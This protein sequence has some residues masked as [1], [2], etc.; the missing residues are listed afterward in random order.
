MMSTSPGRVAA[1]L[2]AEPAAVPLSLEDLPELRAADVLQANEDLARWSRRVFRLS[3][4]HLELRRGQVPH[5]WGLWLH[6][7]AAGVP[8]TLGL[9]KPLAELLL[10]PDQLQLNGMTQPL[11]ELWGA[12]RLAGRMPEGVE[13]RAVALDRDGLSQDCTGAPLK[14][15]WKAVTA[16][17]GQPTA[18]CAGMWC[19]EHPMDDQILAWLR[20]W[21]VGQRPPSLAQCA[22]ALPLV[23]AR[24]TVDAD[25]LADL[26][27]G[28]VLLLN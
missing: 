11:L 5:A 6:V 17:Q 28:D 1:P 22:L 21:A 16:E 4:Q 25:S 2:G 18:L 10:Q 24:W 15:V 7:S 27:V 23:A 14:S 26:A 12:R 8:V 3:G 9:S 20:P 19:G 13:L